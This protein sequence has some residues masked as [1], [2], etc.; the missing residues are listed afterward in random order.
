MNN[1][2][3]YAN[4]FS[5]DR[6]IVIFSLSMILFISPIFVF[7]FVYLYKKQSNINNI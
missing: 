1:T 4:N 7:I 5:F 3:S 2:V 6:G